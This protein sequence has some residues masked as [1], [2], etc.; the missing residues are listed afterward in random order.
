M[1]DLYDLDLFDPNPYQPRVS[2]DHEHI[3]ALAL[4]IAEQ[5]L[6]QIPVGRLKAEIGI[7]TRVQLAFGHSRLEAYKFLNDTG[8]AGFD[9]MPVSLQILTDEQMFALAITENAQRRDLSLIETIQAMQR[10]REDFGKTS[11]EIGGL[12]GL[13][14]SAVR[15]KLRLL[16]LPAD[17][18]Q[19]FDSDPVSERVLRELLVLYDLPE[20]VRISAEKNMPNWRG[21]HRPSEIVNFA[22]TGG[23]AEQIKNMIT[24]MVETISHSMAGSVFKHEDVFEGDYVSPDCKSCPLRIVDDRGVC[25]MDRQCFDRKQTAAKMSYLSGASEVCGI[26]PIEDVNTSYYEVT[27]W[28]GDKEKKLVR[29]GC[30]N[31]RLVYH[32]HGDHG[33]EGFPKAE[34]CCKKGHGQCVCTRAINA[35]L[36]LPEP[37]VGPKPAGKSLMA[38]FAP[39]HEISLDPEPEPAPAVITAD[40]LRQLDREM[41]IRKRQ[42][43]EECKAIREDFTRRVFDG[44]ISRNQ[45]IWHQLV[46]MVVSYQRREAIQDYPVDELWGIIAERMANDIYNLDFADPIPEKILASYN[47]LLERA[48]LPLIESSVSV[49]TE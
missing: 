2:H 16:N 6:L 18:L 47:S 44:L 28:Y 23:T 21:N 35:G 38:V 7:G 32:D 25:C 20:S 5:G 37:K 42:G 12:F 4:S 11:A 27:T 19:R 36:D 8:N 13:S 40:Q 17:V 24:M 10:Y 1:S 3:K 29:T 22:F 34:I 45:V 41:R 31:L 43:M 9:K 39:D 48:G 33:I 15:N 26:P 46:S 49:E 14:E 30:E